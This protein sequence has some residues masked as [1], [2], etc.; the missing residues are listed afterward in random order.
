[1]GIGF[2]SAKRFTEFIQ[3]VIG[4]TVMNRSLQWI[5]SLVKGRGTATGG[6]GIHLINRVRNPLANFVGPLPFNKG[7][8]LC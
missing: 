7:R 4:G 2:I 5:A 6:G 1:M 8:L 3:C